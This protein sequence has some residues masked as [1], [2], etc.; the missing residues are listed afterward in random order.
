V[1]TPYFL[2]R[3]RLDA[4]VDAVLAITMTLLVLELRP[5]AG[6]EQHVLFSLD[7]LVPKI[8]SWIVS[9]TLLGI[10]WYAHTRA[11]SRVEHIDATLFWLTLLWLMVTSLLPFT[12]SLI[13]EHGDLL[14]SHVL[15]GSTL[16]VVELI[17]LIRNHHLRRHPELLN[18]PASSR[19]LL[20][21][22]AVISVIFCA[23]ASMATATA[24]PDYAPAVYFLILPLRRF[25]ERLESAREDAILSD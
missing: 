1:R 14:A 24:W 13:G 9:F 16:I 15:Y 18:A 10:F 11:F 5:P 21:L 3:H 12:S 17:I 25:L 22:P 6:F 4:L 19:S 8:I 2:P 7:T 20:A 23:L